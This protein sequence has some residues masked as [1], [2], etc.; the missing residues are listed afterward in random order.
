MRDDDPSEIMIDYD[1][2][3]IDTSAREI[4]DLVGIDRSGS[5]QK[6]EEDEDVEIHQEDDLI[7]EAN[8]DEIDEMKN[9]I[10]AEQRK[11]QVSTSIPDGIGL[12]D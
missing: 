2:D 10:L 8:D 1:H 12:I 11:L 9:E 5:G 4:E 7:I 6:Y 3:V